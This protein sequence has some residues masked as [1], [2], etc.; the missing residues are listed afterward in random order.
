[1]LDDEKWQSLCDA[2]ESALADVLVAWIAAERKLS[3]VPTGS[4]K[5]SIQHE[6]LDCEGTR[7]NMRCL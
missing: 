4:T 2:L 3:L 7:A 1:M 6:V 5:L